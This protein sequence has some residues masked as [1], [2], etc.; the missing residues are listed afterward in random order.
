MCW[1]VNIFTKTRW[2]VLLLSTVPVML[3]TGK[4]SRMSTVG[5]YTGMRSY[6]NRTTADRNRSLQQ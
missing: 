6:A 3:M 2:V 1:A 5:M 4:A